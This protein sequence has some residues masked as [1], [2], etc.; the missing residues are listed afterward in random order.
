MT[1]PVHLRTAAVDQ[2]IAML[3]RM[4]SSRAVVVLPWFFVLI[5]AALCIAAWHYDEGGLLLFAAFALLLAVVVRAS[6]P[7][8]R[9]AIQALDTARPA[10]ARIDI[11]PLPDYD[12]PHFEAVVS[13]DRHTAWKITFPQTD[14]KPVEGPVDAAFYRVPNIPWPALVITAQGIIWPRAKPTRVNGGGD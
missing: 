1:I 10:H 14:W 8:I 5:A 12:S 3:R 2:Q 9:R 6:I 7:H 4:A 11:N 13:I